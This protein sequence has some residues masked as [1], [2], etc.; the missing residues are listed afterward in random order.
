MTFTAAELKSIKSEY[1]S[2]VSAFALARKHNVSQSTIIWY[3]HKMQ[4]AVRNPV[5]A[6]RLTKRHRK[7][8]LTSELEAIICDRYEAG[9][10]VDELA[11]NFEIS[12]WVVYKIL[13]E[14]GVTLL[15]QNRYTGRLREK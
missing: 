2:G 7:F 9:E 13:H 5:E 15:P 3:L 8:D 12:R 14:G 1:V 4:V 10:S 11:E 6:Q